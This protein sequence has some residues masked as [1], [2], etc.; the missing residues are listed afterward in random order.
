MFSGLH[1]SFASHRGTPLLSTW[2]TI[3]PRLVIRLGPK[4]A[5][6]FECLVFGLGVYV[7]CH[8]LLSQP[9]VNTLI[10]WLDTPFIVLGI[11]LAPLLDAIVDLSKLAFHAMR[12][13][14]VFCIQGI[15]TLVWFPPKMIRAV[16]MRAWK[17]R[18]WTSLRRCR[19]QERARVCSP[20][21]PPPNAR[22]NGPVS[23]PRCLGCPQDDTLRVLSIFPSNSEDGPASVGCGA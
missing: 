16:F 12:G 19:P 18:F 15:W 14:S 2:A 13:R 7:S 8:F 4:M 22:W 6:L 5:S 20:K 3:T 10:Y 17:I 11:L 9:S 23:S 21:D 1:I